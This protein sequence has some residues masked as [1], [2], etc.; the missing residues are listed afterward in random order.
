MSKLFYETPQTE[1]YQIDLE[2]TLL[3]GSVE[4]MNTVAGSWDED[5]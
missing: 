4:S 3:G 5:E 2:G 1:I